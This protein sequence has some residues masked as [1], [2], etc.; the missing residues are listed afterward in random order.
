MPLSVNISHLI[1]IPLLNASKHKRA[2]SITNN[3]LVSLY[4]DDLIN[5]ETNLIFSLS[6]LDILS[7][8]TYIHNQYLKICSKRHARTRISGVSNN[9]FESALLAVFT[10]ALNPSASLTAISASI[11]RLISTLALLR[12]FINVE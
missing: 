2:P 12:P 3:P 4:L 5:L 6:L 7:N 10:S 11:L 8:F 9:Y 1:T